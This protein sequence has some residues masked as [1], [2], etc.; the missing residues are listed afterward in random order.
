MKIA[1]IPST[2]FPFIGGAEVQT[3]NLAN[4]L[5]ELGVEVDLIHLEKKINVKYVAWIVGVIIWNYGFPIV[6]PSYDVVMAILLKHI[7]A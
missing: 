1:F 3:H 2:Y 7:L 4:K 6:P 5:I